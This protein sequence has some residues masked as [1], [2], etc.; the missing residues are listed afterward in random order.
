VTIEAIPS[1]GWRAVYAALDVGDTDYKCVGDCGGRLR[2]VRQGLYRC[3]EC[4]LEI[5]ESPGGALA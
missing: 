1:S 4:G 3:A 5:E 2:E